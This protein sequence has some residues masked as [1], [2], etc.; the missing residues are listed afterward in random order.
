[1]RGSFQIQ[2]GSL[3]FFYLLVKMKNLIQESW[4]TITRKALIR[5]PEFNLKS[6]ITGIILFFIYILCSVNMLYSGS[7]Y[8]YSSVNNILF[9][10]GIIWC[11][12][13][14]TSPSSLQSLEPQI[15]FQWFMKHEFSHLLFD[16]SHF[17]SFSPFPNLIESSSLFTVFCAYVI[18]D[19]TISIMPKSAF[20]LT[21][22]SWSY[23]RKLRFC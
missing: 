17:F 11:P 10:H 15:L 18:S 12:S 16:M 4:Q 3:F 20:Y 22:T 7:V 6:G 9:N 21:M 1:M 2:P 5:W 19:S 14:I 13:I 8:S 23:V